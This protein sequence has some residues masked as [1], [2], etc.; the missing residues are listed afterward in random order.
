MQTTSPSVNK[1]N[2]TRPRNNTNTDVQ[3]E[4]PRL[5]TESL[6]LRAT[7]DAI[8]KVQA[9]IEF[10]LDGTIITANENF[11]KIGRAHV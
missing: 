11:L 9:V 1:K 3:A 5:N 8:N 10:E 6:E 4:A 7:V 2:S